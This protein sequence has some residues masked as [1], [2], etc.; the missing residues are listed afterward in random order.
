MEER[1]KAILSRSTDC[2]KRRNGT[3]GRIGGGRTRG[4]A[5]RA[6]DL[7]VSLSTSSGKANINV[8]I[9]G[10]TARDYGISIGD[11]ITIDYDNLP[12]GCLFVVRKTVEEQGCSIYKAKSGGR[13]ESG[14]RSAFT[15]SKNDIE[16]LFPDGKKRYR[17]LLKHH[18]VEAGAYVFEEIVD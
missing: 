6:D 13:E 11:Y 16:N 1:Y 5:A 10:D 14:V 9:K 18:D 15:P 17:C 7:L 12:E 4:F 8:R 2:L 3:L